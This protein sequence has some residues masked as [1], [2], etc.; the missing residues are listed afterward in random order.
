MRP[1]LYLKPPDN[2]GRGSQACAKGSLAM[3]FIT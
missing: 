2:D 1:H 3:H